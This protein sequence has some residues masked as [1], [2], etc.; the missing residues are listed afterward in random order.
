MSAAACCSLATCSAPP[1]ARRSIAPR[2]AALSSG[3]S[4][5]AS[6]LRP[7]R[8]GASAAWRPAGEPRARPA[9]RPARALPRRGPRGRTLRRRRRR[10]RRREALPLRFQLHFFS[11][12]QLAPPPSLT[13]P[14]SPAAR[15]AALRVVAGNS[16]TGGPFAPIVVI[17]RDAMGKKEFNLFRGK[18]ISLHSQVIKEFCKSIGADSKQAQGLIRTAKKNGE[19]LGFLA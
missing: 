2:A 11:L 9:P 7:P 8:A 14:P 6:P 18:A 17:V 10:R 1:V 5:F 13:A 16:A 12:S 15:R 19:K 4:A 3:S